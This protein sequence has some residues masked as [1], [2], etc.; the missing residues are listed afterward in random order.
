MNVYDYCSGTGSFSEAFLRR[1]HTVHR[2]DLDSRFAEVPFTQITNVCLLSP[3]EDANVVIGGP[4]CERY[5]VAGH[6]KHFRMENGFAVPRD[7]EART[8]EEVTIRVRILGSKAR[9]LILENPRGLMRKARSVE[10]LD[11]LTVWYCQYGD[12]RAKPTDL[13]GIFPLSFTPKTCHNGATDHAPAP[14]GAKSGTQGRD[15]SV[16]R[17]RVPY[18]LSLALCLACERD[19]PQEDRDPKENPSP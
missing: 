15:G 7:A 14:R 1:G 18:D 8:A 13:F 9:F 5:S 2:Y 10:G 19:L 16:D 6:F 11:R 12:E 4:P 3:P 17:A